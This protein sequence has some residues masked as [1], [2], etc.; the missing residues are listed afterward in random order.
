MDTHIAT[1]VQMIHSD[2]AAAALNEPAVRLPDQ[3]KQL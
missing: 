3:G 1:E 2:L